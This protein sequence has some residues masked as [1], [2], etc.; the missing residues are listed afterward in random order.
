MGCDAAGD[1]D[2]VGGDQPVP[3]TSDAATGVPDDRCATVL[4]DDVVSGL[5]WTGTGAAVE[6]AGRCERGG[7]GTLL[8]LGADR[9]VR[10]D[11]GEA[12]VRRAYEEACAGLSDD[13]APVPERDPEWLGLAGDET[14]CVR[15][16]GPDRPGGLVELYTLSDS[17]WLVHGQLTD[18]AETPAD[19]V[20]SA[21]AELVAQAAAA[22]WS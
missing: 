13:G 2:A 18:D 19:D 5:G 8:T 6:S 20:R 16:L 1:A 9:T 3:V 17:G 21:V 11:A 10:P 15:G 14:A 22:D 7:D 4:S 12:R